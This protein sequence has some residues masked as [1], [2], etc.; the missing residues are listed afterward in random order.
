MSDLIFNGYGGAI[1]VAQLIVY[2]IPMIL[3]LGLAAAATT[4]QTDDACDEDVACAMIEDDTCDEDFTSRD[5][6]DRT[7][8][9]DSTT[10][11]FCPGSFDLHSWDIKPRDIKSRTRSVSL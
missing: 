3:F 2:T 1:E 9:N 5:D 6:I 10:S 7:I 4:P 11:H 8:S